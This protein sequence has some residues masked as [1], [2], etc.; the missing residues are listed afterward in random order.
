MRAFF[1]FVLVL[2]TCFVKSQTK[3]SD[4]YKTHFQ[5]GLYL[6]LE[7]NYEK[8]QESFEQAYKI[9]SSSANINYVL[10]ICYLNSA[11]KKTQAEA[12][13]AKSL[14]NISRTYKADDPNEKTASPL[15]HYYYGKAL[16][17]NYKFK[18]AIVQYD[19]FAKYVDARNKEW[20]KMVDKEKATSLFAKEIIANPLQLQ[21]DNMGDSINSPYPEYSAVLSADE[22]TMIFTTRRPNSTGGQL[23]PDGQYFE[24]IVISYKDNEGRWSKPVSLSKNVNTEGHEASINL[25]PDGQTLIVFRGDNGGDIFFSTFDGKDWTP[26]QEFG[27]DV[28][29]KYFE[30]HAC[31]NV[32]GSILFF[33]S[34][35]PGGLGGRDIYRCIK[36]PN[37]KWSKALN[38]GPSINSEYDEDGAFMHPDGTTFFF[39]S[40]GNK[41]MGGFDIMYATLNED[42]Q[43]VDVTNIGYPIN[44]TDDDVFYVTSPDAKR[45]YFTSAKE[46]G[47]GEKDIYRLSIPENKEAFL[48]LFKGQ[49]VPADG[50][51]LPDNLTIVVK[52]KATGKIIGTYLPKLVNGTFSTILPPGKDYNFSYQAANGEEFYNEDIFVTDEQTY[53]EIK[54]EIMLEPVKLIGKVKAKEKGIVLNIITLEN[55]KSKKIM[56]H[57]KV[58]LEE[59]GGTSKTFETDNNGRYEGISLQPDKKY[60]AYA[61]SGE[62]KS[63]LANISTAGVT[64]GK[65]I[66]QILY[67]K[68]KPNKAT[69]K[70]LLLGVIVKNSRTLK[71][72]PNANIT[73]TDSEGENYD[74]TTNDKGEIE[75]I[76]LSPDTKYEIRATT[77]EGAISEKQTLSTKGVNK[78][79]FT[80][81]LLIDSESK[82]EDDY[83]P[84]AQRK[85][86]TSKELLLGVIVRNSK[87]FKI[88]PNVK[89]QLVD[90]DGEFYDVTTN[91]K[92]EIQGIELSP[93]T[94]YELTATSDDGKVSKKQT[95][96][97]VGVTRKSFTKTLYLDQDVA[98]E[99]N[100]RPVTAR[101]KATSRDLLLGVIVRNAKTFKIIPNVKVTL[102][103]AD[104]EFYDVT[105]NEKGEIQ[106][107]ELSPDTKYE[108]TATNSEG[109]VSKKQTLSTVGV[110]NKKFEKTLYID[111]P[112]SRPAVSSSP[113]PEAT[114]ADGDLAVDYEI[115]YKYNRNTIDD[116]DARW[117]S[118]VEKLVELSNAGTV[119]V[120]I[121]ASA[122]K[123]PTRAFKRS[124]LK[125]AQTRASNLQNKITEAV[126]AKGGKKG[127]IS[128]SRSAKVGGPSYKGDWDL[129][130]E[131]YE[132]HQYSKA[133]IK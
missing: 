69:S 68:N 26:L 63:V 133:K 55:S 25:T 126:E 130:R 21:I 114:T 127:N 96:S 11:R 109:K 7:N 59:E 38:V 35:R 89:I 79:R 32:D 121:S 88:I 66:N 122:S 53:R 48:A 107:I 77:N 22:R 30:S 65:I 103:D 43:F 111:M 33:T 5:E 8:A 67:L 71:I 46:G 18:E 50:E 81:T 124:N 31:L 129:G 62:N 75:G 44:T 54:R 83:K 131:K 29:S 12:Y 28:N 47:F 94:K 102:V 120:N 128:F 45:S 78:K 49:I 117:N 39:A 13:F 41:T 99:A 73:L 115:H 61:E 52:D 132:K 64:S 17:I 4:S 37:G 125:L 93:D 72:I 23:T 56:P 110:K 86:N 82:S 106:G 42:N 16:H 87:T 104:G 14:S 90:A 58:S 70:E 80:K 19:E 2:S 95:L 6:L 36:L 3:N 123:V 92:G 34:D 113:E 57:A 20:K 118:F 119:R 10:G 84:V 91:N 76:E 100:F 60:I 1:T 108:L 74:V 40:K 112:D 97:T 101:Q 51:K 105:T 24:D 85:K 116:N 15:A 27:S 98:P 9:D